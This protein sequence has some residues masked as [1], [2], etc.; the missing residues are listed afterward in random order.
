MH[1]GFYGKVLNQ[2]W[3][4]KEMVIVSDEILEKVK[5][6]LNMISDSGLLGAAFGRNQIRNTNIEIRNKFK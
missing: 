5:R 3:G 1:K 4:D 2:D 6:F